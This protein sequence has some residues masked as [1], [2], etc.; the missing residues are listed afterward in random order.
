MGYVGFKIQRGLG[1]LGLL[2]SGFGVGF[3]EY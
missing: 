2:G 1:G 3:Y